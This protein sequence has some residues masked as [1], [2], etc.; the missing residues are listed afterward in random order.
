MKVY[1]GMIKGEMS[2]KMGKLKSETSRRRI[3]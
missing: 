2:R 3:T 1:V